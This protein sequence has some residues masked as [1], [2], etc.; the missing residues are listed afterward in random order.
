M[1]RGQC[2]IMDNVLKKREKE[3]LAQTL[4]EIEQLGMTVKTRYGLGEFDTDHSDTQ[5]QLDYAGQTL[6]YTP[7]VKH[8][9]RQATLGALQHQLQTLGDRQPLLVADYITPQMAETLQAQQVEFVDTAGNAYLHKPPLLIRVTGKPRKD[10]HK[11]IPVNRAFQTS[12]LRV[13]FALLCKPEIADLP[14]RQIASMAGVAHGTVGWVMAELPRLGYL[15]E[16]RKRRV[17]VEYARLLRQWAE[18]YA[19]TLRP[20]MMLAQFRTD[21]ITWWKDLDVTEFQYLLGGE[22]AGARLTGHLRPARVTLYGDAINHQFTTRYRLHEER[23]A[24]NVEILR[25]FWHFPTEPAGLTPKPLIYADLLVTGDT[26]CIETA[27][28]I[29][30]ELVRG[31]E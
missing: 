14:Y 19:R 31:C 16:Y 12:G 25:R 6:Q 5:V 17:L 18:G 9:L 22:A 3:T 30:T 7:V 26:R 2:Q 20:K 10:E 24:G 23:N 13:L 27:E 4:K 11:A 28:I 15:T 21:D 8:N 29:H 1:N